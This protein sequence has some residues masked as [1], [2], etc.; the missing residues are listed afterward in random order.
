[1]AAVGAADG[2]D[3]AANSWLPRITITGGRREFAPDSSLEG[4]E[5][6]LP[7]PGEIGSISTFGE[8]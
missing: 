5:F 7:V 6:E 2:T 3:L 4:D 1:L 8:E